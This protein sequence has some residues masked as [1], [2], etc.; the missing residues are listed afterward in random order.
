MRLLAALIGGL[1]IAG[2][3]R[4]SAAEEYCPVAYFRA[5]HPADLQIAIGE[6][7]DNKG[8]ALI[9]AKVRRAEYEAF[10][11]WIKAG[12]ATP[13]CATRPEL[14]ESDAAPPRPVEIIRHAQ[15]TARPA[16]AS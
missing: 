5:P 1:V 14:A 12:C 8:A 6:K 9:H 11:A 13:A 10:A 7:D 2:A 16:H 15:G 3:G 4:A